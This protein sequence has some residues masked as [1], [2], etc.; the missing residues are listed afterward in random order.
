MNKLA[1]EPKANNNFIGLY[2]FLTVTFG[3]IVLVALVKMGLVKD[4]VWLQILYAY[5]QSASKVIGFAKA[6]AVKAR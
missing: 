3:L 5:P 6:Q 1:N 4:N 2:S